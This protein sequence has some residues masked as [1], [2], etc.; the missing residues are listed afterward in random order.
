MKKTDVAPVALQSGGQFSEAFDEQDSGV[1]DVARALLLQVEAHGEIRLVLARVG[2]ARTAWNTEHGTWT[3]TRQLSVSLFPFGIQFN[4]YPFLSCDWKI[5]F[6]WA[7]VWNAKFKC[8]SFKE[9][10]SELKSSFTQDAWKQDG[11][12]PYRS[13]TIEK[14]QHFCSITAISQLLRCRN[15]LDSQGHVKHFAQGCHFQYVCFNQK[16]RKIASYT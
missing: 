8:A 9:M 11:V 6:C 10:R 13:K 1:A 4:L 14:K 7:L 15:N 2:E 12:V 3:S 5:S 16:V